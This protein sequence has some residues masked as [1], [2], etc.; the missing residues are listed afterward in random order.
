VRLRILWLYPGGRNE[1]IDA[2][3][4]RGVRVSPTDY[5]HRCQPRK[6]QKISRPHADVRVKQHIERLASDQ[7]LLLGKNDRQLQ[8]FVHQRINHGTEIVAF[9]IRCM[10]QKNFEARA[11]Q[12]PKQPLVKLAYRVPHKKLRAKSDADLPVFG[13]M[14]AS[15]MWRCVVQ[16]R[17][18]AR[19]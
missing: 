16:C 10:D 11:I 17:C 18:L 12:M 3:D 1:I 2:I 15:K 6:R 7:A 4:A 9:G 5:L 14:P 19:R 8:H 13:G